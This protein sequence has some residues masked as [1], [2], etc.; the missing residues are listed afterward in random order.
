MVDSKSLT[1][2]Y[3]EG[4]PRKMPAVLL[5]DK[6][7][8]Q[9]MWVLNVHNPADTKA[10]PHNAANRAEALRR[11]HAFVEQLKQS[12]LPV[13]VTGDFNDNKEA[14][15]GMTAGGLTKVADPAGNAGNID[16]VFGTDG[17]SFASTVRDTAPREDKTSDHPLVVTTATF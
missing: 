15:S 17:V 2:P 6:A 12:G 7:T 16:W 5:E 13:I 14:R 8:G 3:F 9:R 11:E 1:I 10:H 4:H